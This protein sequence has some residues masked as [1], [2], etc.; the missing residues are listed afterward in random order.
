MYVNAEEEM[1]T[2][3]TIDD[4]KQWWLEQGVDE[5]QLY[6]FEFIDKG[7]GYI[8]NAMD[9]DA[10]PADIIRVIRDMF[11]QKVSSS[12]ELFDG[13]ED[14]ILE[15]YGE[16][17]SQWIDDGIS[18]DFLSLS[19]LKAMSP[20]NICGGSEEQCLREVTLMCDALNIKYKILS[21]YVF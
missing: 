4:I 6:Q 17:I 15:E 14:K 3:D 19:K 5:E 8:R 10:T 2:E 18:I 7:Y 1:L 16:E 21:Q 11:Q 9:S 20:F 12:H 13:D